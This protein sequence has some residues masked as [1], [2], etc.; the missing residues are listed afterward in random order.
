MGKARKSQFWM[1]NTSGTLVEYTSELN[2]ASLEQMREVLEDTGLNEDDV[3]RMGGIRSAQLP[4]NGYTSLTDTG[5]VKALNAAIRTSVSKTFQYRIG[6]V[7]YNGEAFA[8]GVKQG[9]ADG[10]AI[11]PWS[12]TLMVDG[13][14]NKTSVAL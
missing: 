5:V 6:S 12:A 10:K 13:A 1:D 4:I 2:S 7:Y 14:V 11:I 3:S 9:N 8:D